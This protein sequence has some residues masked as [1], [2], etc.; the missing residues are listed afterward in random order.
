MLVA[1]AV[2]A[3]AR[4]P[5]H[6]LRRLCCANISAKAVC[7]SG[8]PSSG[9]KMPPLR[10]VFVTGNAKKLE[11]VKQI[12]GTEHEDKFVLDA[13]KV[14]LPELQV[15]ETAPRP[16]A[17]IAFWTSPDG[18]RDCGLLRR[19]RSPLRRAPLSRRP[20]APSPLVR[21]SRRT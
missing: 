11:E 19:D 16:L 12:L 2:G 6:S 3:R 15:R 5:S 7:A 13:M 14:D 8:L 4:G 17:A 21:A 9:A 10:I 20:A 18:R 1:R